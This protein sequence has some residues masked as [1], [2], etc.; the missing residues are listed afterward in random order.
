MTRTK[1]SSRL[2]AT[3]LAGAVLLTACGSQGTG[4]ANGPEPVSIAIGEPAA[5]LV[6]GN[7]VEEYGTQILESLWTGLVEYGTDGEVAYT[8]VA[9][10]ISSPDSTT[11]TIALEDGW[12]FHD[13]SPVTAGSFVDAWNYTAYS[14]NGQAGSYFFATVEGYEDLQAPVDDEGEPT[15]D[16]VAAEMSGLRVVDDLTFTVTLSQPFAQFPVTLG[17]NPFFPLPASFF[18]DP[19]AFGTRP[20][21]NGPFRAAGAFVPGEGITLVAA[22]GF[23]GERA[24]AVDAVEYR[25]YA[26][27]ETAYTDALAGNLDVVPRVPADAS[28]TA[29]QDFEGRYAETAASGFTFL[30]LPLYQERYADPRVRQ[31]LSMAIDREAITE[32]VFAGTREPADSV[33][34]PAVDGHRDGACEYCVLDVDRAND[35]LDEAGF[36]RTQPIELWFNAGSGNDAWVQALGNQLRTNLG[37][38]Y[39][40]RGDLAPAEYGPLLF[41]Q[42]M[43]GPFR[44]GWSMDY[45]SPQNFLEPLYSTQ[46]QPPAGSNTAFYSNPVFDALVAQGNQATSSEQAIALYNQAEDVLLQDLPVIP[47]FFD[48]TQSVHSTEV[49]DV[50]VDVFGRVDTTAVTRAG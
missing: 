43:T 33:V 20:V 46:A 23:A 25:V 27:T 12:I 28:E 49:A 17:Y 47:L 30:G 1:R 4:D 21:G 40:L 37:V 42:G 6:P 41:T 18:D 36:D 48:V 3:A 35:L 38:E 31:A 34:P 15:G 45:P 16:P 2:T 5:P 39:V 29:A 8:G 9:E 13:G 19:E 11:W 26:D 14:P 32:A 22:D 7:T 10:S 50:V 44:M 24:P